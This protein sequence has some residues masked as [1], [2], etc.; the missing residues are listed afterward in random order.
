MYF[1][2]SNK[3]TTNLT[4]ENFDTSAAA[5]RELWKRPDFDLATPFSLLD[6]TYGITPL[7][8]ELY[9]RTMKRLS[10]VMKL[11]LSTLLRTIKRDDIP[12]F[13]TLLK[14]S[15]AYIAPVTRSTFTKEQSEEHQANRHALFVIVRDHLSSE[16]RDSPR[17]NM[18]ALTASF[19]LP[20]KIGF[21][22][23]RALLMLRK[24]RVDISKIETEEEANELV[25]TIAASV[26]PLRI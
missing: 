13:G 25:S 26:I 16:R 1:N 17:L 7:Q 15:E 2:N 8:A 5:I 21:S 11:P 9:V 19:D 14:L 3:N 20:S 6:A 23:L 10:N 18:K 24:E 12:D 4:T 22:A